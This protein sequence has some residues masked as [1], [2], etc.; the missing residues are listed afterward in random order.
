[1]LA[2]EARLSESS[3]SMT[4]MA[5]SAVASKRA[6]AEG[7]T[8]E[9][10]RVPAVIGVCLFGSVARGTATA[11]S[12]IDLLVLA[13][14][15]LLTPSVLA[16]RLPSRLAADEPV[17]SSFTPDSLSGYLRKWSRFGV[18]L[19]REGIILHD[20]TGTLRDLLSEEIPV[21]VEAELEVQR[22][23]LRDYA[24]V[25]RFGGRLLFPLARIFSIGRAVVFARLAAGG[26]LEFDRDR[27]FTE[28]ARR[29][30]ALAEQ[31]RL[32]QGLAP[33][34]DRVRDQEPAAPLPFSPVGA[35]AEARLVQARDAVAR[36]LDPEADGS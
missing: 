20:P 29:E 9:L 28:M 36:L 6:M 25:D 4:R 27:A 23:H 12:D 16:A 33:F 5:E 30:P 13:T 18:H 10:A 7:V 17:I 11:G 31:I 14:D 32:I 26:T 8:A 1:L 19:R 22:R 35:E 2:D 3:R 21:S 15:P 34:Y 24:H